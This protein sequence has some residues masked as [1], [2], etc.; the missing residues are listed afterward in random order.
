MFL[1]A[2]DVV[3]Q[4][5]LT[6]QRPLGPVRALDARLTTRLR[7]QFQ[8]GLVH[9]DSQ[10]GGV[11]LLYDGGHHVTHGV[12]FGVI[13]PCPVGPSPRTVAQH[14]VDVLDGQVV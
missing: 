13:Q 11:S 10:T 4:D 3:E 14:H 12:G 2:T 7:G 1:I 5:G 9:Y 8:P 6:V